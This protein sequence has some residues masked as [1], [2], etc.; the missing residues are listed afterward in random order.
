MFK[1][2]TSKTKLKSSESLR[3]LQFYF[4]SSSGQASVVP[5]QN[6]VTE[7]LSFLKSEEEMRKYFN[8]I[9]WDKKACEEEIEKE[10]LKEKEKFSK[11]KK[12]Y[13]NFNRQDLF[14]IAKKFKEKLNLTSSKPGKDYLIPEEVLNYKKQHLKGFE[15]I[16]EF[17][18]ENADIL[19]DKPKNYLLVS[20]FETG[21]DVEE[22]LSLFKE[23][24]EIVKTNVLP[25]LMGRDSMIE[26]Y[27]YT[28]EEARKAKLKF[29]NFIYKSGYALKVAN[30]MDV[31]SEGL[32]ERT[33]VISG[34]DKSVKQQQLL[35][36]LSVNGNVVKLEMP[37]TSANKP[38]D[39]NLSNSRSPV[40]IFN[41]CEKYFKELENNIN[42]AETNEK[43]L[44][45]NKMNF[46][47]E[48]LHK[49]IKDFKNKVMINK[50]EEDSGDY[51]YNSRFNNLLVEIK[52]FMKKFFPNEAINSLIIP[53]LETIQRPNQTWS[54]NTL[55]DRKSEIEDKAY[56]NIIN[57]IE[58]FLKKY[59]DKMNNLAKP[60]SKEEIPID[61]FEGEELTS[62]ANK[63]I[64]PE[65]LDRNLIYES[66]DATETSDPEL[67]N[68]FSKMN[69]YSSFQP[70]EDQIAKLNFI[71]SLS[72][73]E[74]EVLKLKYDV[75]LSVNTPKFL[76]YFINFSR[77]AGVKALDKYIELSEL[78]MS[79]SPL[80]RVYHGKMLLKK[81]QGQDSED[82]RK[83]GFRKDKVLLHSL[84]TFLGLRTQRKLKTVYAIKNLERKFNKS[85]SIKYLNY[86]RDIVLTDLYNMIDK[87]VLPNLTM[88]EYF[89]F[90]RTKNRYVRDKT[91][92]LQALVPVNI[93]KK[94]LFIER[95]RARMIKYN[96]ILRE[97]LSNY[98]LLPSDHP[99]RKKYDTEVNKLAAL[100]FGKYHPL[101]NVDMSVLEDEG[102]E[103][104]GFNTVDSSGKLLE[105]ASQKK[106]TANSSGKNKKQK[107]TSFSRTEYKYS[108]KPLEENQ[109]INR[110]DYIK[111][112]RDKIIN[113]VLRIRNNTFYKSKR[114]DRIGDMVQRNLQEKVNT[115]FQDDPK[116]HAYYLEKINSI[117]NKFKY[118]NTERMN[119]EEK[120][121]K[122]EELVE[123]I[124]QKE[125]DYSQRISRAKYY[126]EN[127]EELLEEKISKNNLVQAFGVY[128]VFYS[129]N[130]KYGDIKYLKNHGNRLIEGSPIFNFFM[131]VKQIFKDELDK[132]KVIKDIKF[133][134]MK[135]DHHLSL[136]E[137]FNKRKELIED[138]ANK[139]GNY[140]KA[141]EIQSSTL[142]ELEEYKLKKLGAGVSGEILNDFLDEDD[143]QGQTG[144]YNNINYLTELKKKEFEIKQNKVKFGAE[145]EE[146]YSDVTAL[147]S[148]LNKIKK[149]NQ[150]VDSSKSLSG[151][152]KIFNS[153]NSKKVTNKG[154]AFVTFANSD[155]AKRI[156]LTALAG[157][158]IGK[159][160][161]KVEPKFDYNHEHFNEE[162]FYKRA[163]LDGNLINKREELLEAEKKLK[164]FE[165]SFW[166]NLDENEK[167]NEFSKAR[168]AFKDQYSDP[169]K[170]H[171]TNNPFTQEDE[172]E[173]KY[174]NKV[175]GV[176]EEN[177]WLFED[178]KIEKLRRSRDKRI[179]NKYTE[180]QLIK[181]GIID[182]EFVDNSNRNGSSAMQSEESARDKFIQPLSNTFFNKSNEFE[183]MQS[184]SLPSPNGRRFN[185]MGTLEFLEKTFGRDGLSISSPAFEKDRREKAVYSEV[186]ELR[187]R[188]PKEKFVEDPQITENLIEEVNSRFI[189]L[190]KEED[191]SDSKK[192]EN[193]KEEIWDKMTNISPVGKKLQLIINERNEQLEDEETR[194]IITMQNFYNR[195]INKHQ[196][197]GKLISHIPETEIGSVASYHLAFHHNQ[198]KIL[199]YVRGTYDPPLN[200]PKKEVEKVTYDPSD[201]S[202]KAFLARRKMFFEERKGEVAKDEKNKTQFDPNNININQVHK[203]KQDVMNDLYSSIKQ[204]YNLYIKNKANLDVNSQDVSVY[205]RNTIYEHLKTNNARKGSDSKRTN[206]LSKEIEAKLRKE[207]LKQKYFEEL[208]KN[209]ANE[210]DTLPAFREH[211][212]N[213]KNGVDSKSNEEESF[214]FL[215]NFSSSI[216]FDKRREEIALLYSDKITPSTFEKTF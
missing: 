105:N 143:R 73:E 186:K 101:S 82:K 23:S 197:K 87:G 201:T 40:D 188:F 125:V 196:M 16:N 69:F 112:A 121:Y 205:N 166:N 71:R 138:Y 64:D 74:K 47:L 9:D 207:K 76:E 24:G 28:D 131:H 86:E 171:D 128:D 72:G 98:E 46:Y 167:L 37:M 11:I 193:T 51:N 129:M 89:S 83:G 81:M 21:K 94:R 104:I 32:P 156:Y 174:R 157:L 151:F 13:Q 61:L 173:I 106:E 59:E 2:L 163:K 177:A 115:L 175:S 30:Y 198:D 160:N 183:P 189:K 184:K 10:F 102:E 84:H 195:K 63:A 60:L 203:V 45:K 150:G 210:L 68:Q 118:V 187:E 103:K 214:S 123:D 56:N 110:L 159:K 93:A 77:A 43:I 176:S 119:F 3:R 216:N 12:E 158:K 144:I 122:L 180:A 7:R 120:Q 147:L 8:L 149:S 135:K 132:V 57:N 49:L 142:E 153:L 55:K 145:N 14:E 6:K 204:K 62:K 52:F 199:R 90:F 67:L 95:I 215:H 165:S 80:E 182:N 162:F 114:F 39:T 36:L 179:V 185:P 100:I 164:D 31:N 200:Q 107:K 130:E 42:L 192:Y 213:L 168:D 85:P 148:N 99:L 139:I 50:S 34:L 25:D 155:Q 29:H 136:D 5:Q 134:E 97:F 70:L 209:F 133:E 113:S 109:I 44:A 117:Q 4:S 178:D 92:Y 65:K 137:M 141:E 208:E 41:T 111:S 78:Y 33:V 75:K 26:V 170:K 19:K 181:R 66:A 1:L 20:G 35:E 79:M 152:E 172:E 96:E 91:R 154:Y 124:I 140:K 206:Q 169:F 15:L 58:S 88:Q 108:G 202:F 18:M 38:N 194:Q 190:L 127:L 116:I 191:M 211:F 54:E 53:E 146:E 212:L 48:Q 22:V 126:F 17:S 27:F 161:V